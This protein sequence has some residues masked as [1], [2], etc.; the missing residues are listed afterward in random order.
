MN[1]FNGAGKGEFDLHLD[2]S[3]PYELVGVEE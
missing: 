3:Q 2:D 1:I